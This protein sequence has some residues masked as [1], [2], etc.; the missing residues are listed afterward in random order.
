[1]PWLRWLGAGF[2]PRRPWPFRGR[3]VVKKA[4]L[5]QVFLP[6]LQLSHVSIISP[7]FHT[8]LPLILLLSE[9]RAGETWGNFK[10]T[11][12]LSDIGGSVALKRTFTFFLSLQVC[13][14]NNHWFYFF[15]K[16]S[17]FEFG[18]TPVRILIAWQAYV[19]SSDSSDSSV[20]WNR[21]FRSCLIRSFA[22]IPWKRLT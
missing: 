5:G 20:P 21:L 12:T 18:M 2:S 17:C 3:C 10:Q 8:H 4:V 15:L 6:V 19:I 7:V 22:W 1:L 9:G 11:N 16:N 13:N 14:D